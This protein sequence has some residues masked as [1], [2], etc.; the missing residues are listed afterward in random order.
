MELLMITWCCLNTGFPRN[1][2][3]GHGHSSLGGGGF[4]NGVVHGYATYGGGSG[5]GGSKGPY[6]GPFGDQKGGGKGYGVGPRFLR[7]TN[8]ALSGSEHL[9]VSE[10]V[11]R[12]VMFVGV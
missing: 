4:G 2:G 12:R 1:S 5:S 11:N 6:T 10:C 8:V 3:G 7:Q 9:L